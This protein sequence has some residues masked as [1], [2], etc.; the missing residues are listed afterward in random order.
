ML[1]MSMLITS[2]FPKSCSN[3]SQDI[4]SKTPDAAS[5]GK[6][7]NYLNTEAPQFN[8]FLFRPCSEKKQS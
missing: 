6:I 5:M 1:A 8:Q 3:G 4:P 7:H 2:V